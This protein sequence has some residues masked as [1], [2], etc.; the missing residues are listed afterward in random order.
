M[1][2]ILIFETRKEV[3]KEYKI[4]VVVT[5]MSSNLRKDLEAAG[6]VRGLSSGF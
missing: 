5:I 2:L 6:V 4:G 1:Y 3:G